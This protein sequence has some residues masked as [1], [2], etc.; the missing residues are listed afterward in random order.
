MRL[1]APIA[2]I[3]VISGFDIQTRLVGHSALYRMVL[4]HWPRLRAFLNKRIFDH[5]LNCNNSYLAAFVTFTG[6]E[7][8]RENMSNARSIKG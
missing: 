7:L 2:V 1:A 5:R 3:T 4:T 8:C 6:L